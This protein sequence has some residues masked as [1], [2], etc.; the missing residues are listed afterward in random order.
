ML[1]FKV[2]VGES[3]WD[4][5]AESNS[6][7]IGQLKSNLVG[8]SKIPSEQQKWIFQQKTLED[9]LT[10][11]DANIQEGSTVTV[12]KVIPG[13]SVVASHNGVRTP[14]QAQMR[15]PGAI[16]I[17]NTRKFQLLEKRLSCPD[18]IHFS[19]GTIE[20]RL[21]HIPQILRF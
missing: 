18:S 6:T 13:S 8:N 7:Q 21:R 19:P 5:T 15:A 1:S 12:E 14:P 17:N 3:T 9:Y 16:A 4:I 10:V 20:V 11:K 2:Q